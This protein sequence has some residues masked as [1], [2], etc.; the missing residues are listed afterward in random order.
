MS[1]KLFSGI[2]FVTNNIN[3]KKDRTMRDTEILPATTSAI[4][5][6]VH[7]HPRTEVL[8]SDARKFTLQPIFA[9]C[10]APYLGTAMQFSPVL[11]KAYFLLCTP[12]PPPPPHRVL[13][14]GISTVFLCSRIKTSSVHV[15]KGIVKS[16]ILWFLNF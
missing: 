15:C 13:R 9:F 16:H 11:R 6:F 14:S 12:P 1:F 3:V 4:G 7:S 5:A 8:A 10:H 2:K